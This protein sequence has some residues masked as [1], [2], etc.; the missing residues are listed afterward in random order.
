MATTYTEPE[1]TRIQQ[2]WKDSNLILQV[3]FQTFI[4]VFLLFFASTSQIE[5][6]AGAES[7]LIFTPIAEDSWIITTSLVFLYLGSALCYFGVIVERFRPEAGLFM[8]FIGGI[9]LILT[10]RFVH[11]IGLI[12][13]CHQAW[14]IAAQTYRR[15][16]LWTILL[17]LS[18]TF[19]VVFLLVLPTYGYSVYLEEV[20]SFSEWI[21]SPLN[22]GMTGMSFAMV[23]LA[24]ALS[25]QY[26][27]NARRSMLRIQ[28][29]QDRAEYAAVAERNR[30]AREMHDIVAHSLTVMI[31]QADGGRFAGQKDPAK[32]LHALGTI[33][34]VGRDALGQMRSLLSVLRD[35]QAPDRSLG[36]DGGITGIDDLVREARRAGAD[37]D[38]TVTGTPQNL[39]ASISLSV[40]RIVQE[41]LTNVLKHAG[42][43]PVKVTLRW[44]EPSDGQQLRI[45]VSNINGVG[46]VETE[47][48]LPGRGLIGIAERAKL[49]GGTASWGQYGD[50]WRVEVTLPLTS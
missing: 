34:E 8:V 42:P 27:K 12:L 20:T 22:L 37:V 5:D 47:S 31:A 1:T 23:Y 41:A 28:A 50:N 11:L 49:H 35:D 14:F 17:Y 46:L 16:T 4:T 36:V 24:I 48:E 32:A 29:L 19:G 3:V 18:A 21:F 43:V 6:E 7:L 38:Y 10:M 25:W 45:V 33:S 15:R 39:G 13:I 30:I 2:W 44:P 40:Y 26:G 9:L